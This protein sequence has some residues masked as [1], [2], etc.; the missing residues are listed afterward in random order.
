MHAYT[1]FIAAHPWLVAYG[2]LAAFFSSFGQTFFVA[3]FGGELRAA[4][5][6]SHTTY[7]ALYS[8][9]TLASGLTLTGFGHVM[10]RMALRRYTLC[11][12][13]AAGVAALGMA[14]VP[15][16]AVLA[17]AFFAVRLT[18]QGL[19]THMSAVAMGRVF[20]RDRGKAVSLAALGHP[21]GEAVLPGLA[22]AAMAAVGWRGTWL[23]IGLVMLL[24]VPALMVWLLRRSGAGAGERPAAGHGGRDTALGGV[25][26]DPLF[27]LVAACVLAPPIVVTGMFFHQVALIEA[28]GWSM[29]WLASSYA[30]FAATTALSSL[31]AG[32]LVDRLGSR[33]V[34]P[35]YLLPLAAGLAVLALG[36]GRWVLPLYMG[37]MGASAGANFTVVGAIWADLYG[38]AHLGAI[39]GFVQTLIVLSTA[40]TPV[41]VGWVLDAGITFAGIALAF[42]AYAAGCA[43]VLTAAQPMLR[44][45]M[46]W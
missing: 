21:L 25:V 20:A 27:V 8:G 4:F 38:T 37:L 24:I 34:L 28:K 36:E 1:R 11:V 41:A 42:A 3:L 43:G 2:L 26:R 22:V 23:A 30:A 10:D 46:G 29:G 19:L 5:E 9:A 16:A 13:L 14:A 12:C 18:G 44:R 40:A 17:L 45:R 7:G 6:L 35:A 32:S 33:R 15:S 39:R 31:G